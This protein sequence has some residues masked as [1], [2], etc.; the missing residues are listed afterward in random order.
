MRLTPD[1]ENTHAGYWMMNTRTVSMSILL[2]DE[3][4]YFLEDRGKIV[5]V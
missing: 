3:H 1:V 2:D 4:L 5:T